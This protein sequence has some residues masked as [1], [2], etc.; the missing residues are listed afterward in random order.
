MLSRAVRLTLVF[1]V[2]VAGLS[3]ALAGPAIRVLL[4]RGAFTKESTRLTALALACYAPGLVGIGG[5]LLLLRAYQA[6]QELGRM[7]WIGIGVVALNLALMPALTALIGFRGLPIAVSASTIALFVVM[8]LAIRHRLPDLGFWAVLG[9]AFR[10]LV[11]GMVAAVC[12][13]LARELGRGVAV[14]DLAAG[15]IVG[16]STYAILLSWLSRKDAEAALGFVAPF[17][18][19]RP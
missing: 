3:I 19:R 11:A 16:V 9:S 7:V 4:E 12:S 1:T 15:A 14:S 10:I 2:P 8:L 17:L 13:W 5:A 6:L 18:L